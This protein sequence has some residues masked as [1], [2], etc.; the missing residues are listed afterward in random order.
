M[1]NSLAELLYLSL[2][3]LKMR[4]ISGTSGSSGLGSVNKEQIDKSTETEKN[5]ILSFTSN[6]KADQILLIQILDTGTTVGLQP[7]RKQEIVFSITK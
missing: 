2:S 7:L 5:K 4:A 1:V 3:V 6:D